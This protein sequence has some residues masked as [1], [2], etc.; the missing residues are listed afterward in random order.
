MG[1]VITNSLIPRTVLKQGKK[2]GNL[3]YSGRRQNGNNN[4]PSL[5]PIP[6]VSSHGAGTIISSSYNANT[7][8]SN[9]LSFQQS[10]NITPEPKPIP[11]YQIAGCEEK[12]ESR[13]AGEILEEDS[14]VD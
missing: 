4:F 7:T 8:N 14:A 6:V 12:K 2:E 5:F 13:V 3:V 1:K 11:G 10:S 9:T